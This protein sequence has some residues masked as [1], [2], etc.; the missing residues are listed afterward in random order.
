MSLLT[1]PS[2]AALYGSSAANGV[3]LITTKKGVTGKVKVTYSNSTTFSTPTFL[4]KFQNTYGNTSG[5]SQSWGK[6][7]ETPTSYDPADF[8]NT[9]VNE[10]NSFT[11]TTGTE[12]NKHT[13]LLPQLILR[14]FSRIT[15]TIATTSLFATRRNSGETS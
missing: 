8:F 14:V 3:V 11:F 15:P 12:N 4:P 1:G 7:L 2:A 10:I 6:K 9:G 5:D 13:L